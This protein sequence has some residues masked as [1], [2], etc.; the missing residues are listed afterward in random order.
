MYNQRTAMGKF[1]PIYLVPIAWILYFL[2]LWPN[3]F[4]ENAHG[5]FATSTEIWADWVV[6]LTYASRFERFPPAFWFD[7]HPLFDGIAL[8]YHFLMNLVSGLLLRIG[9][10][11]VWAQL[12][13]T[14]LCTTALC[15][16]LFT[17]YR[18]LM[19]SPQKAAAGLTLFFLGGGLGFWWFLQDWMQPGAGL[20]ALLY[21]GKGYATRAETQL[22][23][24]S[25][26]THLLL[27][28]KPLQLGAVAGLGIFLT[29]LSWA[30]RDR[31]PAPSLRA[32]LGLGILI[33]LMPIIHVHAFLVIS[34]ACAI[35]GVRH[36]RQWKAF[37]PVLI[38]GAALTVTTLLLF[39][40][41]SFSGS[42]M[43]WQPG[44]L[45][46]TDGRQSIGF[47]G[48]W[49]LNW[50]VF[51]PLV[52]LGIWKSEATRHFFTYLG[53]GAF[54]A[55][56]F[57]R[58]QPWDWD[59]T[60]IFFWAYLLLIPAVI[61]ALAWIEA[62]KLLVYRVTAGM[63]FLLMTATGL[64]ECA[65]HLPGKAIPYVLWNREEIELSNFLRSRI[66]YS[67]RVLVADHHHDW[68]S[69]L[70]GAQILLGFP[71]WIWSTGIDYHE[72]QSDLRSIF[73][74]RPQAIDLLNH[75]KVTYAVINDTTRA[76][77][78]VNQVFFDATFKLLLK[79]GSTAIYELS[80]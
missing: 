21:A 65:R 54:V 75:Y 39:H 28:Q 71:G 37:L 27:P 20:E 32:Q 9:F 18:R 38:G 10:S 1:K 22:K 72:R 4:Y 70:C 73:E 11:R 3:L 61:E 23:F 19:S 31:G 67:D 64:I 14:L 66:K 62:R 2:I 33:G 56:N 36:R 12:V 35:F 59:N 57:I 50:S 41:Q 16:L 29:L 51:L 44:W 53:F 5:L 47:V 79:S 13:P 49:L 34:A 48:F 76:S 63:L 46:Y 55:A 6:H 17:F 15:G 74:G 8:K 40:R 45:A 58:F 69:A 60:K 24:G 78:K 30:K 26:F 52:I 80:R 43:A 25:L 68:A 42:F 77:Y 7:N